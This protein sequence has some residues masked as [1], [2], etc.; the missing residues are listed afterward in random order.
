MPIDINEIVQINK[1][2]I[3]PE[4]KYF[5]P[6][7]GGYVLS[8]TGGYGIVIEGTTANP[9]VEVDASIIASKAWVASQG[10]ITNAVTSISTGSSNAI[11]NVVF[12]GDVRYDTATKTFTFSGAGSVGITSSDNS[13][14]ITSSNNTYDLSITQTLNNYATKTYLTANTVGSISVNSGSPTT[15]VI[16][17]QGEGITQSGNTITFEGG[18][19]TVISYPWNITTSSEQIVNVIKCSSFGQLGFMSA[20]QP[21]SNVSETG[22]IKFDISAQHSKGANPSLGNPLVNIT[23]RELNAFALGQDK[24]T[25]EAVLELNPQAYFF[26]KNSECYI[27]ITVNSS[28]LTPTSSTIMMSAQLDTPYNT[29]AIGQTPTQFATAQSVTL[30]LIPEDNDTQG[31]KGSL[32]KNL[33]MLL[34][35]SPVDRVAKFNYGYK[36]NGIGA[37]GGFTISCDQQD[38]LAFPAVAQLALGVTWGRFTNNQYILVLAPNI[39]YTSSSGA[40][41]TQVTGSG[42]FNSSYVEDFVY[43][44]KTSKYYFVMN[45]GI[46]YSTPALTTKVTTEAN[47]SSNGGGLSSIDFNPTT[48]N[49][50]ICGDRNADVYRSTGNGVWT[51]VF[52]VVGASS[53][54][55]LRYSATA[56]IKNSNNT[57]TTGGWC[58]VGTMNATNASFIAY[59][60]DDGLTFSLQT[61]SAI[62][63]QGSI[64]SVLAVADT[65]YFGG[66]YGDP[67]SG[68]LKGLTGSGYLNDVIALGS[69]PATMGACVDLAYDGTSIYAG[70]FRGGGVV[71]TVVANFGSNQWD[72]C[73]NDIYNN[74]F[75][76]GNR[77]T[78]VVSFGKKTSQDPTPSIMWY[79]PTGV[80]INYS[81]TDVLLPRP[82]MNYLSNGTND[83]RVATVQDITDAI[84]TTLPVSLTTNWTTPPASTTAYSIGSSVAPIALTIPATSKASQWHCR[85]ICPTSPSGTTVLATAATIDVWVSATIPAG[86]TGQGCVYVE[87]PSSIIAAATASLQFRLNFTAPNGQLIRMV[88]NGTSTTNTNRLYSLPDYTGTNGSATVDSVMWEIHCSAGT[89]GLATGDIIRIQA[90]TVANNYI[91]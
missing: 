20:Q 25:F 21:I 55:Q 46:V 31:G 47:L 59:S 57:Y 10:Y 63:S 70:S 34:T 14:A 39:Y 23:L 41:W 32:L 91:A 73:Q 76:C 12:A 78:S 71:K 62:L 28:T 6:I 48:G 4:R 22:Y 82:S 15:G 19:E 90:P 80:P 60:T 2:S 72:V 1:T 77:T 9:V 44:T 45:D 16:Q 75:M 36:N 64:N 89:T 68:V 17:F 30:T 40:V 74:G 5:E 50:V 79:R 8:V 18:G 84:K 54:Q 24:T 27:V 51:K 88:R 67:N 26:Y 13:V 69:V 87:L 56:K 86:F 81:F 42:M 53:A 3:N 38:I 7:G 66:Y 49:M 35:L 33:D 37:D 43:N 58:V 65:W 29:T 85:I 83:I 11:G 61:G 52:A